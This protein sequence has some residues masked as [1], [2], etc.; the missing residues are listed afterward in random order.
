MK[1][2]LTN[3]AL[4][5]AAALSLLWPSLSLA[6]G[7]PQP[8]QTTQTSKR[9]PAKLGAKRPHRPA[10]KPSRPVVKPA[11]PAP[12]GPAIK[13][14]RARP[15]HTGK[16]GR[17]PTM[18][19]PGHRPPTVHPLPPRQNQFYHR[20]SWFGRIRGPL[21]AY[22]R[23]WHYRRWAIGLRLPAILFAPSYY[24]SDWS[25]LGLEPPLPGYAW[26]RFGPDLLLVNLRTG[27]VEDVVYGVFY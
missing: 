8:G 27:E 4:V 14:H 12:G 10:A 6:Q 1:Q 11:K 3:R 18:G 24:Y 13:P 7:N 2:R 19:K 15:P 20:G 22:P 9:G 21:Y 5:V 17:P 25:A 26:V 16:P 23:G